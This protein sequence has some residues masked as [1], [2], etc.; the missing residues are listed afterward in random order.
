MSQE[1]T[2]PRFS[3]ERFEAFLEAL[4]ARDFDTVA[5]LVESG[6]KFRS[7]FGGAEGAAP[8]TG[9]E[10]MRQW[11]TE[12]DSVWEDWHQEVVDFRQVS[13]DQAVMIVRATAKAKS[14]GIPLDSVTGNLLSWH[15]DKGWEMI[16]Y[17]DPRKA[18]EAAGLS[19]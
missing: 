19:E 4:N 7:L 16:A 14:S 17:S 18:L 6:L 12:V 13:D 1:N 8:Y 2:P 9:I 3:R 5:T 15:D 11:A 10:G